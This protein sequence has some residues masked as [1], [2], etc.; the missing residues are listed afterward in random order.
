MPSCATLNIR[1][2][3]IDVSNAVPALLA[4]STNAPASSWLRRYVDNR[5]E[6]IDADIHHFEVNADQ[7]K[8]LF[9]SLTNGGGVRNW[10]AEDG[11][12]PELLD[13]GLVSAYADSAAQAPYGHGTYFGLVVLAF[14]D[15]RFFDSVCWQMKG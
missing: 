2:V 11:V 4:A 14:H 5:A 6:F 3:L 8:Q 13:F 10:R 1:L 7:A 9:L 15:L 12:R